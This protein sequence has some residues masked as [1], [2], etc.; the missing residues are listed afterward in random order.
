MRL[1]V[2]YVGNRNYS[3]WSMRGSLLAR[4]SGLEFQEEVIPLYTAEG[5]E[6]LLAISPS[7]R[8]PCLH[9]EG[10][11]I[12]DSL[13]IAE[14]LHERFPAAG[15]WPADP[16]GRALAR[17]ICAEMHSGF[18]GIRGTLSMDMRAS[19]PKTDLPEVLRSEIRRIESI[20]RDCRERYAAQGDFLFGAWSGA[21]CFF[22]PV[23]SR[24][25]TY[26]VELNGASRRYADAVWVRPEVQDW[27]QAAAA[28]P[29]ELDYSHPGGVRVR[30][31]AVTGRV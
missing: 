27:A 21:D 30:E 5:R 16:A 31:I 20:W 15:I 13:A 10:L 28:E 19:R 9:I 11:R 25:R 14:F 3:S 1:A 2:L 29:W 18:T 17:C 4:L 23:V 6:R 26:G 12:W 7:G 24:F 22:A 8:V